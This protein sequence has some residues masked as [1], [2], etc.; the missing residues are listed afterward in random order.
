MG[1]WFKEQGSLEFTKTGFPVFRKLFVGE[2]NKLIDQEFKTVTKISEQAKSRPANE[3]VGW[4]EDALCRAG[5]DYWKAKQEIFRGANPKNP[6]KPRAGTYKKL[7]NT[8]SIGLEVD[9]GEGDGYLRL[10]ASALRLMWEVDG[11]N[12]IRNAYDHIAGKAMAAALDKYE[13]KRGEGGVFYSRSEFDDEHL[14][15]GGDSVS[16][17]HG[18]LGYQSQRFAMTGKRTK[19]TFKEYKQ[20][21]A[22]SRRATSMYRSPYSRF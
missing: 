20:H 11:K 4:V 13:W 1:H 12:A 14:G 19:P 6:L 16:Q 3:R 2:I 5:V 17:W 9:V 22:R 15:P 18:P 10:D 21:V 8:G 7:A